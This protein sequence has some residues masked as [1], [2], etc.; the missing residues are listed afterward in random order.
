MVKPTVAEIRSWQRE[1]LIFRGLIYN[2][3]RAIFDDG[4]DVV[5]VPTRIHDSVNYLLLETEVC[6]F[7]LEKSEE[8]KS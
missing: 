2:D 5:V 7:K 8:K 6:L 3:R 1:G 4:E